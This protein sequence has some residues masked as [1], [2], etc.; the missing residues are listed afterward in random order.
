MATPT[1]QP[2]APSQNSVDR[3]YNQC[4]LAY[5]LAYFVANMLIRIPQPDYLESKELRERLFLYLPLAIQLIDD[6][7]N[8]EGSTGVVALDVPDI[9]DDC[10]NLVS[11]V[12]LIMKGWVDE[13]DSGLVKFWEDR[14]RDLRDDTAQT[15]RTAEVFTRIVSEKDSIGKLG[16]AE[17]SF[18][19]AEQM[20]GSSTP[21]IL[22]TVLAAYRNSIAGAAASIRLCNRLIADLTGLDT[23]AENEG[24]FRSS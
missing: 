18:Q 24:S 10:V 17:S 1:P 22:P 11:E 8:V 9:R 23:L 3:D 13:A 20:S 21:F 4:S 16:S 15:Y 7:L 14:L 12:R 5:R 2:V 6:D 19:L